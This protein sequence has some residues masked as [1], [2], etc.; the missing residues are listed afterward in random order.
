MISVVMP[1]Y[2]AEETIGQ[3][4]ESVLAQTYTDF[5]FIIVDDGSADSTLSIAQSYAARDPRI[6]VIAAEHQGNGG[7]RNVGLQLAAGPWIAVMDADDQAM[8]ERF[9]TQLAAAEADPE[10]VV[11]GAAS[12]NVDV[13]G[14]LL[15]IYNMGPASK[16]EFERMRRHAE[17]VQV[18]HPTAFYRRDLALAIG[19]YDNAFK[20]STDA[21]FFDRM[22]LHG[23]ILTLPVPLMKSRIMSSSLTM[24][25]YRE[26]RFNARYVSD[27]QRRRLAGLPPISLDE[28]RLQLQRAPLWQ[29]ARMRQD[30]LEDLFYLR[31][32]MAYGQKNLIRAGQYFIL[33][34][35]INPFYAIPKIW[36]S[37]LSPASRGAIRAS[38]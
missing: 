26:Q 1:A 19:G 36:K 38:A 25:R 7:A 33:S 9:A 35:L 14:N 10:V 8:P 5:E 30:E 22:A 2:N 16:D 4:I 32:G 37:R 23:P 34:V 28:Y 15:T 24:Q 12:Y 17:I 29:R 13:D 3:V 20:V 21:E 31:A 11:W 6:R 27:R 18:S